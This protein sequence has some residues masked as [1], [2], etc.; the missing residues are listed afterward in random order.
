MI[1]DHFHTADGKSLSD[2]L[3]FFH[4]SK[5]KNKQTKQLPTFSGRTYV[6]LWQQPRREVQSKTSL[7]SCILGVRLMHC[8]VQYLNASYLIS[9]METLLKFISF[10]WDQAG[11]CNLVHPAVQDPERLRDQQGTIQI[12]SARWCLST[13]DKNERSLSC[14]RF[15]F[16]PVLN[17]N[18]FSF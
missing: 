2:V 3:S 12:P 7:S 17:M 4:F 14:L 16:P 15:I 11:V 10:D 13:R 1:K 5:T 8:T 9:S 18:A 6:V